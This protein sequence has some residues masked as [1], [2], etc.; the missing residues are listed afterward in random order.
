MIEKEARVNEVRW[1]VWPLTHPLHVSGPTQTSSGHNQSTITAA[2]SA[3][4]LITTNMCICNTSL[5][6][7]RAYVKAMP[8]QTQ[9]AAGRHSQCVSAATHC[10]DEDATR[11]NAVQV[12]SPPSGLNTID[13]ATSSSCSKLSSERRHAD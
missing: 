11:P 4:T 2:F 12:T 5:Y 7:R 8:E 3:C 10:F 13:D 9:N 6:R 1:P